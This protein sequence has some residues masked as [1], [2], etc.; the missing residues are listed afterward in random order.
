[1]PSFRMMGLNSST[2]GVEKQ[3]APAQSQYWCVPSIC[4][5]ERS[6]DGAASPFPCLPG[7]GFSGGGSV[8]RALPARQTGRVSAP[9]AQKAPRIPCTG[10]KPR[11]AVRTKTVRK[12]PLRPTAP[13]M[14]PVAR[15]FRPRYHFWAQD[16]MD[17]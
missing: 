3:T 4:R 11:S 7:R 10:P 16:W 1:M 17:G 15:P 12:A 5:G 6:R 9:S 14:T 8:R 2:A 13:P